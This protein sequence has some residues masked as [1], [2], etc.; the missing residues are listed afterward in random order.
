MRTVDTLTLGEFI[1]QLQALEAEHGPEVY[2][3]RHDELHNEPVR[4]CAP[5]IQPGWVYEDDCFFT[6]RP[7]DD[8]KGPPIK[9]IVL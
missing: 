9:L 4:V 2:I 6:L 8:P 3:T 1:K 5:Y 7:P